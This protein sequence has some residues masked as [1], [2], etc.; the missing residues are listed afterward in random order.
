MDDTGHSRCETVT[1]LL[2]DEVGLAEHSPDMPLKALHDILNDDEVVTVGISNWVLD[3]AKMNRAVCLQRP[4]PDQSDLE[5]IGTVLVNDSNEEN[6]KMADKLRK[7]AK[8][9]QRREL[10][11]I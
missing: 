5:L 8:V 2:L 1:V 4:D 3:P 6:L 11:F 7:L 9:R 10:R